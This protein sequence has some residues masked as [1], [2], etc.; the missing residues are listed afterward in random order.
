[1][2]VKSIFKKL[3]RMKFEVLLIGLLQ[4][5]SA[6][7]ETTPF[8]LPPF[9]MQVPWKTSMVRVQGYDTTVFVSKDATGNRL[10]ADYGDAHYLQNI[11]DPLIKLSDANCSIEKKTPQEALAVCKL[12]SAPNKAIM[13]VL[14][15]KV[16]PEKQLLSVVNS[17][18]QV[19][20]AASIKIIS[21]SVNVN[22]KGKRSSAVI[23][24]ESNIARTVKLGDRV[25]DHFGTVKKI[26]KS[27]IEVHQYI[28]DA[29]PSDGKEKTT[30]LALP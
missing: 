13:L 24:D 21:V 2:L 4:A 1:M 29:D 11:K 7:A 18:R 3:V 19:G 22:D 16:D 10:V 27:G 12:P 6:S 5:A 14:T 23:I 15:S 8:W 30:K 20:K 28:Y 26:S 9:F 17:M 25:M